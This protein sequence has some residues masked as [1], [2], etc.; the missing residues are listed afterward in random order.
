MFGERTRY[1]IIE[2]PTR[3]V[4]KEESN[5]NTG[6]PAFSPTQ[7]RTDERNA[8]YFSMSRAIQDWQ[9]KDIPDGCVIRCS[10]WPLDGYG[11]AWPV[12]WPVRV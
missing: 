6:R 7:N 11:D 3:G 8:R 9:E 1:Y 2:H 5:P 4:L 10:Q 12:V